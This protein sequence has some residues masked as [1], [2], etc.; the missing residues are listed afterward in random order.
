M[1]EEL[2]LGDGNVLHPITKIKDFFILSRYKGSKIDVNKWVLKVGGSVHKPMERSYEELTESYPR[3]SEVITMECVINPV[4]GRLVGTAVWSGV[5]LRD[6]LNEV[7]VKE[8]TVE[9]FCKSEDGVNRGLPLDFFQN[10][11]TLL[12]YE[13][14]GQTLPVEYGFPLRLVVPGLYGFVWR[15]WLKELILTEVK[16]ADPQWLKSMELVKSKKVVLTT[17]ILKPHNDEVINSKPYFV[18]GVS[19]GGEK[20][21]HRVDVSFDKGLT[22]N[23][24]KIIWRHT[25]HYAWVIWRLLWVPPAEGLYV[26]TARAI[27]ERGS[28]QIDGKDAYPSGLGRLHRVK[29][30]VQKIRV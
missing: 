18:A 12:A 24:A 15:K 6:V 17:K 9:L 1:I 26:V 11:L 14:N 23:P 5:P 21:I 29:V 28:V 27:D 8:G 20:P 7:E 10:P 22:W 13:M 25:H 19:W 16:Y 4:G 30:S 3:V 2:S